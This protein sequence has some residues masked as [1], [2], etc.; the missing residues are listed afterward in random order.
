M[1]LI[2][3][4]NIYRKAKNN[5]FKDETQIDLNSTRNQKYVDTSRPTDHSVKGNNLPKDIL[6]HIDLTVIEHV[7]CDSNFCFQ[8]HNKFIIREKRK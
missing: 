7:V 3:S 5:S 2:S 4:Y 8:K 1:V 6:N